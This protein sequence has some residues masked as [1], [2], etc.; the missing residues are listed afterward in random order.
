M[1]MITGSTT[2]SKNDR[3]DLTG[4]SSSALEDSGASQPVRY[5]LETLNPPA[6][7]AEAQPTRNDYVASSD[8]CISY[9]T[10]DTTHRPYIYYRDRNPQPPP[11]PC[12]T[13][14]CDES[15]SNLSTQR[16]MYYH[17][18]DSYHTSPI[19]PPPS[20]GSQY[21]S[22]VLSCPS[23]S[24][25]TAGQSSTYFKPRPPPPSPLLLAKL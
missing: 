23:S 1:S 25:S 14:V 12:S 4:T 13:D 15:D 3:G 16:R 8:D 10:N 20:P 11:T 5:P 7:T 24:S 21:L 17:H 6:A 9:G 22:E 19:P 18:H 2:T